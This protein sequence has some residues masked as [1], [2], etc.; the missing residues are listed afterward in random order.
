MAAAACLLLCSTV[1]VRCCGL[2]SRPL[3]PAEDVLRLVCLA[4]ANSTIA[5]SNLLRAAIHLLRC[6]VAVNLL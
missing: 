1:T 3:A 6:I 5:A 2:T 4:V